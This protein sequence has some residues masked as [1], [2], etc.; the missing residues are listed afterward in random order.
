MKKRGFTLVAILVVVA[1]IAILVIVMYGKGAGTTTA[2]RPDGKGETIIGKSLYAAKD[3]VC[4]NDLSN[5]RASIAINTDP[6]EGT[7]PAKL[8]DTHLGSQ[9]YK[10]PVGGEPYNYDPKTGKVSCPHP[11]HESY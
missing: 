4:R 8:E 6:I 9:F 5:L 11:G 3:D 7:K 10:C 1:I 2:A